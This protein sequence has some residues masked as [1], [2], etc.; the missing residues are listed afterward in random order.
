MSGSRTEILRLLLRGSREDRASQSLPVIAFAVVTALTLT[1]AGGAE[2]FFTLGDPPGMEDMG[3]AGMYAGMA[4]VAVSL[5]TIPLLALSTSAVRL[6]TRRRDTRLS[7]LRLLGAPGSLLRQVAVVEAALLAALGAAAGVLLHL[8][9][10]PLF[11][12]LR[13]AGTTL[14]AGQIIPPLGIGLLVVTV[15]VGTATVAAVLGLQK[16]SITPLGVRTRQD[17]PPLR[18]LQAVA[19]LALL[20]GLYVVSQNLSQLRDE[21]MIVVVTAGMFGMGLAVL[22]LIGPPVLA[23][24]ARR[25]AR[26]ADGPR[27]AERLLAARTLLDDPRATWRMVSGVAMVSFVSVVVGVAA[28]LAGDV[29]VTR[30]EDAILVTD[31]RTGVL[32]TIGLS[33]LTLAAAVAVH[34]AAE[35]FDR[36]QLYVALD[37]LGM[38]RATIDRALS[39]AVLEPVVTVTVIGAAAGVLLTLPLAGMALLTGPATIGLVLGSLVLA[40]V[41]VRGALATTR[42]VLRQ[43]LAQTQPVV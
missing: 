26:R 38:P 4:G 29:D 28:S 10:A 37:R 31:M 6:S 32:L 25:A 11:G 40:L 13:F 1:V 36:R 27:A 20:V 8:L 16:V 30:P 24:R 43:V 22:G 34:A 23:A 17:A 3:M 9:T 33:Y 42:P 35:V 18:W 14:G 41:V 15:I 21:L 5:L 7:S 39:R 12:M 19:G 2:F